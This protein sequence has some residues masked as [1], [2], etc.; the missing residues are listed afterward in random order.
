MRANV[1]QSLEA[2]PKGCVTTDR[3]KMSRVQ[4]DPDPRS[5]EKMLIQPRYEHPVQRAGK[6]GTCQP[7]L[8][9]S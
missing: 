7:P 5:G 3:I 8:G 9:G 2:S 1:S 4:K 6:A